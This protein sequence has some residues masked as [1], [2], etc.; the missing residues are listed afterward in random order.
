MRQSIQIQAKLARIGIVLGF[1]I[2]TPRADKGRILELMSGKDKDAFL[3]TLPL[4]YDSATVSTVEQIDVL[5]LKGRFI[6]QAFEVEHTTA[7]Y[8]GLLRMADLMALQ[9]NLDIRLHIVAP[10]ERRQKR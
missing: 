2:W 8:S 7:V 3:D 9:P 6:A 10:V 4:N 1:K 5:W